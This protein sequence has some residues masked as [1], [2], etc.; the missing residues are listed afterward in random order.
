MNK[1]FEKRKDDFDNKVCPDCGA[2]LVAATEKQY[3]KGTSVETHGVYMVCSSKQ[4]KADV[5]AGKSPC[6]FADFIHPRAGGEVDRE[7][8]CKKYPVGH[9]REEKKPQDE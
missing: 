4:S 2:K 8:V 9:V 1:V 6:V 7:N 3:P 5:E